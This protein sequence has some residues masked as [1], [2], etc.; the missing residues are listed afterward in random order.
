[1]IK[2]PP[3]PS[4]LIHNEEWLKHFCSYK[5]QRSILHWANEHKDQRTFKIEIKEGEE[6]QNFVTL[7]FKGGKITF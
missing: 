4:K 1:M 5:Q 2:R 6:A 3:S 7:Y